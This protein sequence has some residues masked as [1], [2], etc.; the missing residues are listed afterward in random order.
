METAKVFQALGEP[1]LAVLR[2]LEERGELDDVKLASA[3]LL[4]IGLVSTTVNHLVELG[5]VKTV[6]QEP[7]IFALDAQAFEQLRQQLAA[8]PEALFA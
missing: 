2:S 4:P 7:D 5:L 1:E 3:S 6:S 8:E